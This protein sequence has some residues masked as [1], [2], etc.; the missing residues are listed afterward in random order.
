MA[1]GA[2]HADFKRIIFFE[3]EQRERGWIAMQMNNGPLK[4][5][6]GVL[7]NASRIRQ[8]GKRV[9]RNRGSGDNDLKDKG[10]FWHKIT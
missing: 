2:Q 1:D 5:G 10:L 4:G 3:R 8:N 6:A 9:M 7:L